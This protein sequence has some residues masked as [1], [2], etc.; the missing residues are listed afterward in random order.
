MKDFFEL[1][2]KRY[3]LPEFLASYIMLVFY[4]ISGLYIIFKAIKSFRQKIKKRFIKRIVD[5]DLHPY[6]THNEIYKYTKYYMPQYYQNIT[7]SEGEELGKIHAAAARSKLMPEFLKK[8]L[9][10]ESPVKYFIILS[11]TGMG[12]TAFLINLYKKYKKKR[13]GLN[14]VKYDIHL[15][16]LG[17]KDALNNIKGIQDK[18][19]TIL[20]LD[21]FDEDI[22]AV[23]DYKHRMIEI[24]EEVRDF[25]KVIFTC[26]TQF[27]PS[28]DE[29]PMDT[30]DITFGENIK[31]SIHKLYLSAFDNKD[32][33]KY[34]FKKYELNFFR[35]F[36]AYNLVKKCPSLMFRPMLLTYI[37]DLIEGKLFYF[38]IK[39]IK[40]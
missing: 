2:V 18:R 14:G 35:L 4:I 13:L 3:G 40:Y 8:G 27:F 38:H 39:C 37:D 11:D 29:E 21:A 23:I 25:R 33:L 1:L 28:K 10:T 9:L 36:R 31:H 19:N 17:A 12:K 7:P 26:R 24:L 20:L 6:F 34:L 32:I 5:Q 22:K 16:P 30:D 15:F